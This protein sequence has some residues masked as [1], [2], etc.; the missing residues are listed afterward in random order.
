MGIITGR[1]KNKIALSFITKLKELELS[2]Q[3][4]LD[5]QLTIQC[6]SNY[7]ASFHIG[8]STVK[9]ELIKS[10]SESCCGD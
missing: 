10:K 9:E 5:H 2:T 4:C 3:A 7:L 8:P 6:C 1:G